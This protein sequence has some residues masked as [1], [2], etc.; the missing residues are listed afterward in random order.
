MVKYSPLRGP[1]SPKPPRTC[2]SCGLTTR[3]P[4]IEERH[5][6]GCSEAHLLDILVEPQDLARPEVDPRGEG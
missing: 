1:L 6:R 4:N 3:G 2:K 5:I